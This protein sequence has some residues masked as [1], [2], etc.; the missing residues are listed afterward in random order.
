[1]KFPGLAEVITR[2]H[3]VLIL[4]SCSTSPFPLEAPTGHAV[5]AM[6]GMV[7]MVTMVTVVSVVGDA[8]ETHPETPEMRK[9]FRV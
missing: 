6:V 2:G 5:V 3:S 7:G 9:K 8:S 4:S 1:M